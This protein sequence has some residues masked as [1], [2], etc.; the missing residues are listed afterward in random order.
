LHADEQTFAAHLG[1]NVFIATLHLAHGSQHVL[2]KEKLIRKRQDGI[3]QNLNA[4]CQL[5]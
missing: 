3:L 1:D 2:T 4:L 5:L